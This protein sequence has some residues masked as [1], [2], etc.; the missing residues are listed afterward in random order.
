MAPWGAVAQKTKVK[1]TSK[2][3]SYVLTSLMAPGVI[4]VA[5]L[6]WGRL[7][8]EVK[9]LYFNNNN[10]NNNNNNSY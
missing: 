9:H 3:R 1:Q 2:P 5:N 6:T 10:N 7:P 4:N 8:A